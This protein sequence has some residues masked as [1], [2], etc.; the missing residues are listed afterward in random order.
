MIAIL[1]FAGFLAEASVSAGIYGSLLWKF[2]LEHNPLS[3]WMKRYNI[4]R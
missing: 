1:W 2:I 4:S 3:R